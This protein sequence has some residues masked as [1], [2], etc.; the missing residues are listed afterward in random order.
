[1]SELDL[2]H[3]VRTFDRYN[4][5]NSGE[6]QMLWAEYKQIRDE[7]KALRAIGMKMCDCDGDMNAVHVPHGIFAEFREAMGD[8]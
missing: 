1:M 7:L 2:P 6:I 4:G 8:G 5:P 3:F